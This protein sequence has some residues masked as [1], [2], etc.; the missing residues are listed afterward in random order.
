MTMKV[1]CILSTTPELEPHHQ[2]QFSVILW[3]PIYV[4]VLI[5][6]RRYCQHILNPTDK[7]G[8][9]LIYTA[10]YTTKENLMPLKTYF[11]NYSTGQQN[12][13]CIDINHCLFNVLIS[14]IKFVF[15]C[16][17]LFIHLF[18]AIEVFQ[19]IKIIV[20]HHRSSEEACD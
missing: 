8:P 3:T 11:L 10:S 14:K 17:L 15:S 18:I 1:Y 6:G 9:V 12:F 7:T 19:N 16:M 20:C 2:M 13:C 5:Y 4:G